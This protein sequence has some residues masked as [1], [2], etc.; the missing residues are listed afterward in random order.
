MRTEGEEEV[1][2]DA[3]WFGFGLTAMVVA[4]SAVGNE[5]NIAAM[6]APTLRPLAR[7][8]G[9]KPTAVADLSPERQAV[10][11]RRNSEKIQASD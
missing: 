5:I 6:R 1:P 2:I 4:S 3:V 7:V 11:V 8:L 10:T 9:P